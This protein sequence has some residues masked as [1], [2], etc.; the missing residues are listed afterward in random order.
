MNIILYYST[1]Y[2]TNVRKTHVVQLFFNSSSVISKIKKIKKIINSS[3]NDTVMN[4]IHEIEET[5]HVV[6]KKIH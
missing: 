3:I 4:P 5:R 2:L 1:A 6:A